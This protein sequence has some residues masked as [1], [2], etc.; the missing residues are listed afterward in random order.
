MHS[1]SE[2]QAFET[3]SITK[4]LREQKLERII[5]EMPIINRV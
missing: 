2:A 1:G 5:Q 3:L 4:L